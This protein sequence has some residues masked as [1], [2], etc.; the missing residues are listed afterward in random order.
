LSRLL[1]VWDC[2]LWSRDVFLPG[3]A[4]WMSMKLFGIPLCRGRL[5]FGHL[6]YVVFIVKAVSEH[7]PEVSERPFQRV[8]NGLLL[9]FFK[10]GGFPGGVSDFTVANVLKKSGRA[11]RGELHELH[12]TSR[13]LESLCIWPSSRALPFHYLRRPI[14]PVSACIKLSCP[15]RTKSNCMF[16]IELD[17]PL[18]PNT[19]LAKLMAFSA[20]R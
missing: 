4:T 3:H 18:N 20:A 7:V 12:D 15:G 13:L 8:R 11:P 6:G 2:M 5:D 9:C 14:P 16:W 10:S 19:S 17:Q 1:A